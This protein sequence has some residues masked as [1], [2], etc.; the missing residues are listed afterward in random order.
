MKRA[1]KQRNFGKSEMPSIA[2][3]C[4]QELPRARKNQETFERLTV[5]I[6]WSNY[7]R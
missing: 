1:M 7:E 3:Q 5:N 2:A 4:M 6:R